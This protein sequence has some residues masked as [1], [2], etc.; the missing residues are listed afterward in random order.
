MEKS[1]KNSLLNTCNQ[2]LDKPVKPIVEALSL[3]SRRWVLRILWE[4]KTE[5]SGFREMQARCENLSPDTLSTRLSEM[6]DAQLIVQG[7]DGLWQLSPLGK[8]LQPALMQVND[9]AHE[10]VNIRAMRNSD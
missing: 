6:K 1:K 8:K 4:L 10:W 3:L 2:P 7:G 5:P 9:W